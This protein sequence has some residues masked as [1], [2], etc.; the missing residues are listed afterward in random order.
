M[1]SCVSLPEVSDEEMSQRISGRVNNYS[2][3]KRVVKAVIG[4]GAVKP[5]T[6]CWEPVS[7]E[8]AGEAAW[9]TFAAIDAWDGTH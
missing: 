9:N 1:G 8:A 6:L 5:F 4:A 7:R 2:R 3:L